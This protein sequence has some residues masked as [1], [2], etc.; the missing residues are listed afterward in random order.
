MGARAKKRD[1]PR[2]SA[3]PEP[4]GG[5]PPEPAIAPEEIRAIRKRLGLSQAEAG[6]LLGGGPRAFTK[7]EA[8]TVKPAAAVVTLLRL[9]Q[10][11]PD[12]IGQLRPSKSSPMAPSF[13]SP[14][15][16]EISGEHI[17]RFNQQL[18]PDLLRRLLHA[19]AL[20][21]G[22]PT[23][24][25]HVASNATAPDGGEDGRI[26]WQEGPDRTPN[27]PSRL[28]QF[29]L[30]AGPI[31]PVQA[32]KEV[33]HGGRVKPMVDAVLTAGG[34]HYRI[35][36][37]HPYTQRAIESREQRV[38]KAVR[39]AG[40]DV[41]DSQITFWDADQTA[42]WVNQHPAVALWV[43]EKTQPGTVG[44]FHSW[45][46]WD[47]H[48]DHDNSPWVPDERLAPL[49]ARLLELAAS[50]RTLRLVGLSGIG[51]SRLALE[52]LGADG[53]DTLRDIV[54]YADA[55]E[56]DA[57]AIVQTVEALADAGT[58][59]VV[60]VNRC[61]PKT[62]RQL[63]SKVS[64]HG[65]QLSLA[66]LD[67]EIPT[68]TLDEDTTK[69]ENAPADVVEAIIKGLLP[70]S[71]PMDRQRLAHF[72]EGFPRIAIDVANAW[73]SSRPIA[74]AKDDDIVDAFVLGRQTVDPDRTL[75]A[76][77]LLAAFGV[78]AVE[79]G[80]EQL[81][82]VA[83]FRHDL[84]VED[85]RIAIGRLAERGV[86]RRKGRLRVLQPRPIAMRLAERQ[87][88]EWS[89][90]Q[91]ERLLTRDDP[92]F[93]PLRKTAAR[94]LARL[95]TTS[96]AEEV[97][98]H[99]CRPGRSIQPDVLFEFAAIAP[100][101]VLRTIQS[102]LDDDDRSS[103]LIGNARRSVV[104]VLEGIAFRAA[105]FT[106]AARLLLPL[107]AAET[108]SYANNAIGV[109]V[110]LFCVR[111]GSTAADG[112]ARLSFLDEAIDTADSGE[113]P[114]VVQALI[115]S[116]SPMAWRIVGAEIQGSRPALSPWLPPTREAE[117]EYMNGCL[118]RLADIAAEQRCGW[119]TGTARSGLGS[120]LRWWID[121]GYD[122]GALEKA[123]RQVA[124]VAG[125]WPQAIESLSLVLRTKAK[126]HGPD[127]IRR[128]R[129]LVES[130]RPTTLDDRLHFLVTAMP[131]DYPTDEDL[132][133]DDLDRRQE[134]AIRHLALD[135]AKAPHVLDGALAK[136]SYGEQRKALV[137]GEVLGELP[138]L[139]KPHIWRRRITQA[140]LKAS[141]EDRNLSLLIGYFFGIAR[142]CPKLEVPLKKRLVRCPTIATAL[143]PLCNLLGVRKPDL[144][145]AIDALE[146]GTLTPAALK[147]WEFGA[148]LRDLYPIE[149]AV[150]FDALLAHK[151]GEALRAVV[152]LIHAYS[153][154][155]MERLDSL[156]SQVRKCISRYADPRCKDEERVPDQ[157]E[158]LAGWMLKSGRHD[159]DACE[160]ALDLAKMMVE[161]GELPG[162]LSR[163]LLKDFPEV[164][165]PYIGAAIVANAETAGRMR[166]ALA[167]GDTRLILALP[168]ATLLS[169]CRAHPD[170]APA[171]AASVLPVLD[172][173]RDEPVLHLWLKR[174][175][176]EFGERE[177]VLAGVEI[178][179]GTYNWFGSMTRYFRQ[180]LGPFDALT[181]H[182][183]PAVRHWAE[184]VAA[185][186]R[187]NIERARDYDEEVDAEW[188]M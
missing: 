126:S 20:T 21:H 186:L 110:R 53:V 23:D 47:G 51:K 145:L 113:R 41:E 182:Q 36:C 112:E 166:D 138:E 58:R 55:S 146:A 137:F 80:G 140:A 85:L 48:P 54:M 91:R 149:V 165:W 38:R 133:P 152:G 90:E 69:V 35:L 151:S 98:R 161:C 82:H 65:S 61:S 13:A 86:V 1:A 46:H 175:I 135:L 156:R 37:A 132:D 104:S 100:E 134:E 78:V 168:P 143:P 4:S 11:N 96:T 102:T 111:P 183:K 144:E 154:A 131:W 39:D 169:W 163:L 52:A 171:F 136:L 7:Y 34:G 184:G 108:E 115:R 76:A 77:M 159:D 32:G 177:D 153:F 117:R 157:L 179:I 14:S 121:H 101:V 33:L 3:P 107:A 5:Q 128:V 2:P 97:V 50:R 17:E 119:P 16:F 24:G 70:M 114:V 95:N 19:E 170:V 88:L 49:Q 127:V 120:Q 106:Q 87:W 68:T 92:T 72:A 40:C 142:E 10:S 71:P 174:L 123:V 83:S 42:A 30:K 84:S 60:V 56:A 130:L 125:V 8:G 164:V 63:E 81:N 44:P 105:T 160:A 162:D 129:A 188:D 22:L 141:E 116:L 94:A 25:I 185:R 124:S 178:N 109:F 6:E 27:L 62:H 172:G 181:D 89:P 118:S 15:R 176:D 173:Q 75:R 155:A 122:I 66:T 148:A 150:L 59:A 57:S 43:R 93:I 99:V 139:F 167:A 12:L 28:T 180:F 73:R 26:R 64:R 79:G 31:T 18:F 158:Q 29:Q 67:D 45:T 9:L 74:H 187:A 103:E 147:Q